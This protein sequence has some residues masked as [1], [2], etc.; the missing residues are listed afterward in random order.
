MD[1]RAYLLAMASGGTALTAGCLTG[2]FES[3]ESDVVL[4]EPENQRIE[5]STLPYPAYGEAFPA[6]SLPAAT[7]DVTIDTGDLN[8]VAVVTAFFASCPAECGILLNQL[9]GVQGLT[10]ERNIAEGVYFLPITFDPERD[11]ADS[12]RRHANNLGVDLEAGNWY[13]LRPETPDEAKAVLTGELGFAFER[14]DGG[15]LDEG[16]DFTHSVLTWLVNPDGFVE[17]VYRGEQL[18]RQ[19]VADDIETLVEEFGLVGR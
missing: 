13:Y 8:R 2:V 14:T 12:L 10:I 7:R 1:R 17:R 5:S 3:S 19:R 16:Y 9:A 18:D 15:R 6:F 4:P 11:D